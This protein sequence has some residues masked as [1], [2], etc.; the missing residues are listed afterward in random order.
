MRRPPRRKTVNCCGPASQCVAAVLTEA[1]RGRACRRCALG[2]RRLAIV[3]LANNAAQPMLSA[4]GRLVVTY[5]GEIYNF[6]ELRS[7]LEQKGIHFRT[8][9]DTEVLLHLYASHG[10]AMVQRL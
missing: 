6:P 5:N 1:A 3:D 7:E 8:S 10:P 2:H 4:D 9:C